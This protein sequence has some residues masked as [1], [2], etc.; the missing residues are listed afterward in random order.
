MRAIGEFDAV[1]EGEMIR[2]PESLRE[3]LDNSVR[4]HVVLQ[5]PEKPAAPRSSD[6]PRDAITELMENPICIPDFRM[7][8]RDEMHER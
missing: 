3:A 5:A 6:R 1:M 7:P 8:T 4:F 2:V